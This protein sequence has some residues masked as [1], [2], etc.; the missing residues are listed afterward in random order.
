MVS[1]WELFVCSPLQMSSKLRRFFFTDKI[2]GTKLYTKKSLKSKI[3]EYTHKRIFLFAFPLK[4]RDVHQAS[5]SGQKLV[6][7]LL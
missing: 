5:P 3:Q 1:E 2:L 6:S 4:C 7:P